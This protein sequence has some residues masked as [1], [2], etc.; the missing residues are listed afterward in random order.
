MTGIFINYRRK[1]TAEFARKLHDILSTKYDVEIFLDEHEIDLGQDWRHR[2]KEALRKAEIVLV[3]IGPKWVELLHNRQESGE[4]DWVHF[5]IAMGLQCKYVI[6]ILC[7]QTQ[8]PTEKE[9]ENNRELIDLRYRQALKVEDTKHVTKDQKN[10]LFDSMEHAANL[11]R[12]QDCKEY[13]ATAEEEDGETASED[14][15]ETNEQIVEEFTP[16]YY[17]DQLLTKIEESGGYLYDTLEK[18][19]KDLKANPVDALTVRQTTLD[20]Q[21]YARLLA[22]ADI[23]TAEKGN[24]ERNEKNQDDPLHYGY[25]E[26]IERASSPKKRLAYAAWRALAFYEEYNK[27]QKGGRGSKNAGFGSTPGEPE[28]DYRL[29]IRRHVWV[30]QLKDTWQEF[31]SQEFIG[32]AMFAVILALAFAM[33]TVLTQNFMFP[34]PDLHPDGCWYFNPSEAIGS[35]W[36]GL[37]FSALAWLITAGV[38]WRVAWLY[39]KATYGRTVNLFS[40]LGL[41]VVF[42]ISMGLFVWLLDNNEAALRA[43]APPALDFTLGFVA[44]GALAL[45]GAILMLAMIGWSSVI[46]GRRRT[47]TIPRVH[48]FITIF[49]TMIGL[50]LSVLLLAAAAEKSRP[51]VEEALLL[52]FLWGLVLGFAIWLVRRI[53]LFYETGSGRR[54]RRILASVPVRLAFVCLIS[55]IFATGMTHAGETLFEDIDI[56]Q[57]PQNNQYLAVPTLADST[58]SDPAVQDFLQADGDAISLTQIVLL[59]LWVGTAV[60]FSVEVMNSKMMN[61]EPAVD[62]L[63]SPSEQ[64]EDLNRL[65]QSPPGGEE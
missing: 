28:I 10:R 48:W 12:I 39:S 42:F 52:V 51:H 27:P 21:E 23:Q 14:T 2:I 24:T 45:P 65:R 47:R 13:M 29:S 54:L 30:Q 9:L 61:P 44:S 36:Q 22:R 20:L 4:D 19:R 26:L 64:L 5:E 18:E 43:G 62:P 15:P 41:I 57:W 17:K 40:L 8:L 37:G 7:D 11:Y 34:N 25:R 35:C 31:V 55:V 33:H 59:A 60:F 3:L 6:P 63:K 38:G 49:A 32:G 58:D 1:D 56:L 50:L 46:V 53:D 16:R